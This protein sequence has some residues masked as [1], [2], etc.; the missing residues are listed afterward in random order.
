MNTVSHPGLTDVQAKAR[1]DLG[2]DEHHRRI[3][4]RRFLPDEPRQGALANIR[5]L[6][7]LC[8]RDDGLALEMPIRQGLGDEYPRKRAASLDQLTVRSSFV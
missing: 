6:L 2:T 4:K 5:A 1:S 8:T 3:S 7:V